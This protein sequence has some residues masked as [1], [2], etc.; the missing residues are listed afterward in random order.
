MKRTRNRKIGRVSQAKIEQSGAERSGAERSSVERSTAEQSR[1]EQ[2]RAERGA[3]GNEKANIVSQAEYLSLSFPLSLSSEIRNFVSSL[4]SGA[5]YAVLKELITTSTFH[6]KTQSNDFSHT[7][8]AYPYLL[9]DLS[10]THADFRFKATLFNLF[11][12]QS[13]PLTPPSILSATTS[14]YAS[15]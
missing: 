4:A 14:A 13:L 1:A 10:H 15:S 7:R 12:G 6:I 9:I 5:E 11:D 2:R 3:R 8:T